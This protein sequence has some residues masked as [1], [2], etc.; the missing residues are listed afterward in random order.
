MV[1]K[2]EQILHGLNEAQREAVEAIQGPLVVLAGPGSGKTR[3]IT[4]RVAYLIEVCGVRPYNI[5]AV[6]FTNKAANEMIGRLRGLIGEAVAHLNIGTFHSVCSKLLRIEGE[7]IGIDSKYVIYDDADQLAV[8]KQ[9]IKQLKIDEKL[10]SARGLL[11]QIS[12][13]KSKLLDPQAFGS[14]A[15]SYY[16]EVVGRVYEVYQNLLQSNR[17]LDFDDLLMMAVRLFD[18]RAEVRE[19]YQSRFVH[20]VVDEFQDTN[21]AQNTLIK[22]LTGPYRNVCVVG[23]PDQSIYSWRNADIRNILDFEK[24]YPD[25]KMVYLDQNYRSTKRILSLADHVISVNQMRKQKGLWTE[26]QEGVPITFHESWDEQD[27]ARLVVGEIESLLNDGGCQAR[28]CAVMYRINAQSR[29]LEEAFV[30]YGLPYRLIG[31]TRFYERKEIKD[32]VAYL[33]LIYNPYDTVSLG[34]IINVP[35]RGIGQKTVEELQSWA[36][37][38]GL[39]VGAALA[40]LASLSDGDSDKSE[41]SLGSAVRQKLIPFAAILGELVAES[42]SLDVLA[43]FDR[44][45]ERSGYGDYTRHLPDGDERWDNLKEFRSVAQEFVD[46]P[47]KQG[48]AALLER[49]ALVSDADSY[50]ESAGAVTLI[51]LHAAKGLEFSSVFIVGLEQ[52]LLPHSRSLDNP[53]A[54][55]E[56]RRLFYVGITRAKERLYLTRARRRLIFGTR[57]ETAPSKFLDDIPRNVISV[58]QGSGVRGQKA[59]GGG[60]RV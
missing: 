20:V 7:R 23:D 18:E 15:Q 49:V 2:A 43:L 25:A 41:P 33:R 10:Y 4:H 50:D 16:E 19:K 48:L 39:P 58:G 47:P 55:E 17:A 32:V 9:A 30:R 44:L 12:S 21:L 37:R 42:E 29:A 45:I 34:R 14:R 54:T 26:N 53:D 22:Q 6:T 59:E 35:A 8:I 36:A 3:V 46:L 56:E 40:R 60:W 52:G 31:G 1:S 27:E 24:D 38:C 11:S 57:M 13:A 28:D 51:T 5:L